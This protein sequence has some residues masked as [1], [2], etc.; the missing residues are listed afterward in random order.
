M[1]FRWSGVISLRPPLQVHC[2][3]V[4]T[5]WSDRGWTMLTYIP[6]VPPGPHSHTCASH[7][8]TVRYECTVTGGTDIDRINGIKRAKT[9]KLK[10]WAAPGV[11]QDLTDAVA[12]LAPARSALEEPNFNGVSSRLDIRLPSGFHLPSMDAHHRCHG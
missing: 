12:R 4:P 2:C 10:G 3:V 8:S 5:T 7:L 11:P 9:L 1:H 6:P